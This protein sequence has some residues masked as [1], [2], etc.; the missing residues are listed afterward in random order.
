M[1]ILSRGVGN[2]IHNPQLALENYIILTII[3]FNMKS[4]KVQEQRSI[5]IVLSRQH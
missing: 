4:P 1:S 5:S 3:T 2:K